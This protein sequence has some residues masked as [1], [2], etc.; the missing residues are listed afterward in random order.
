MTDRTKKAPASQGVFVDL[1]AVFGTRRAEEILSPKWIVSF[2]ERM[3]RATSEVAGILAS[4]RRGK[5]KWTK[6][7]E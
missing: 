3:A 7:V 6:G 5:A 4:R 1:E 2:H